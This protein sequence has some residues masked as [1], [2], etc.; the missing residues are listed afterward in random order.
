MSSRTANI[1]RFQ[2]GTFEYLYDDYAS[3]EATGRVR[4][5]PVLEARLVAVSGYS[6]F[7]EKARD[8]R[9]ANH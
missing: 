8:E 9:F 4:Y 1:V 5:D 7:Q 6:Q 2:C 3:L